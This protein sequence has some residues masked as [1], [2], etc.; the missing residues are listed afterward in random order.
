MAAPPD[1]REELE[2]KL[3]KVRG[4]LERT[5]AAAAVLGSQGAFAWITGGGDNHVSLGH[6]EGAAAVLVTPTRACVLAANNE[7]SRIVDEEV[8][9][10]PLEPVTWPW[11]Q[12][13]QARSLID[14]LAGPGPVVADLGQ[15]G[16]ARADAS[17]T[18]L[19]FTL[20]ASEVERYRRL[21]ADAAAAVEAACAEARPGQRERDVA[22]RVVLACAAR[23]I[24]PLVVLVAGDERIA[25]YRHPQ[26]TDYRW[27]RTLLVA[28]TGR[29][30]G[31]H[32]SLTRM[33]SAR[34]PDATLAARFR[35]VQRVDAA[36][37]LASR[38]GASLGDVL[39]RGQAQY[40][41]EGFPDEWTLHHQGGLTGYAGRERFAVPGEA[42]ALAAAQ[43]V[44][45]NPSITSVKS[46]DTALV[47]D[48]GIEL[49]TT[50]S[51][52]PRDRVDLHDGVVE[53][54]ALMVSES[55]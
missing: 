47:T 15:L 31:L 29:R 45:W 35:A 28:L 48:A 33:V 50:T 51:R 12:P 42:L 46:E 54:P 2:D 11:H 40:A 22:A 43:V 17:L 1:R 8:A 34:A 36:M 6:E 49:L 20:R 10:L 25:R 53:R 26:P 38:P 13:S 23:G 19:R 41:A 52:W 21:G 18:A 39:A 14:R 4:W 7:L 9:G 24:I 32:A 44:A 55:S 30:H 3:A 5:G 16:L 37:L 27:Q